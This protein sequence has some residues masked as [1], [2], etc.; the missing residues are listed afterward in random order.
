MLPGHQDFGDVS[1]E[2][3]SDEL[4]FVA[5]IGQGQTGQ[6]YKARCRSLEVAVKMLRAESH[7]V[8]AIVAEVRMLRCVCRQPLALLLL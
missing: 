6:V 2:I 7:D 4:A 1:S 3:A 8:E 5:Q